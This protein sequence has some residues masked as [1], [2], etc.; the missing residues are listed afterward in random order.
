MAGKPEEFVAIALEELAF[1]WASQARH[2]LVP[3]LGTF[4]FANRG[5]FEVCQCFE[6]DLLGVHLIPFWLGTAYVGATKR[7]VPNASSS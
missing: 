4:T 1:R 3:N 6:C 7:C 5:G 2:Y